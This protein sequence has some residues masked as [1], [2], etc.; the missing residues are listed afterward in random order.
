[1][2]NIYNTTNQTINWIDDRT[3]TANPVRLDLIH[4]PTGWVGTINP[5]PADGIVDLSLYMH[6]LYEC[7][8]TDTV[9]LEVVTRFTIKIN[10][11]VSLTLPENSRV[12]VVGYY[13]QQA[14]TVPFASDLD[15][16]HKIITDNVFAESIQN[17][18][19]KFLPKNHEAN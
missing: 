18:P 6:G 5:L 17:L 2:L 8:I 1:M 7:T 12:P 13:S 19:A 15:T 14:I 16:Y 10:D 3:E 11:I 4:I 9:T